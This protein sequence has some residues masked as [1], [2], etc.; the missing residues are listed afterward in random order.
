MSMNK[1]MIFDLPIEIFSIIITYCDETDLRYLRKI[2]KLKRY[3]SIID[4]HMDFIGFKT[5]NYWN[6][7]YFKNIYNN[8]IKLIENHKLGLHLDADRWH[9][10]MINQVQSN[11]EFNQY[12]YDILNTQNLIGELI[13]MYPKLI[14]NIGKLIY[15]YHNHDLSIIPPLLQEKRAQLLD[16]INYVIKEYFKQHSIKQDTTN[17]KCYTVDNPFIENPRIDENFLNS[18]IN[19]VH[20]DTILDDNI[21][22]ETILKK[23]AFGYRKDYKTWSL[24]LPYKTPFSNTLTNSLW[25][26]KRLPV[27]LPIEIYPV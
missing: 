26:F 20:L 5:R 2:P 22:F 7:L 12:Y 16:N 13:S 23:K 3:Y 1:N 10:T 15:K 11:L 8:L 25:Y 9:P 17:F 4:K 6:S 21:Q 24:W 19:F 27:N 14:Y 18:L